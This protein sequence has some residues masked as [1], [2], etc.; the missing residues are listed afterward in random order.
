MRNMYKL[1]L[2]AAIFILAAIN[3]NAQSNSN[4][5]ILT[6]GGFEQWDR[7]GKPSG[8]RIQESLYPEQVK[9]SRPGGS[10]TEALKVYF[11]ELSFYLD[12]SVPV[13]TETKYT[14]SFWY[15]G[16]L[17]YKEIKLSALW[18][19]DGSI[20]KRDY[21]FILATTDKDEWKQAKGVI[22][23]PSDIDAMTMKVKVDYGYN[24]HV[25]FDDFS[26]IP[27][28]G[29]ISEPE[30]EAP[31]N[32]KIT[33][34]QGEMEISW[35]KVDDSEVQWEVTFDDN[36]ETTTTENVFVKTNLVPGSN[37]T[38]K[39]RAVKGDVKSEFSEKSELT[40]SMEKGI[41][42]PKRI[43]YLRT[44]T[45]DG[46][47]EGRTLK[48]YFNE[49]ANPEAKISYK[50]NGNPIEP[51]NN[52]LEFPAFNEDFKKFQLEVF[53]NEDEGRE[54]EITYPQLGVKNK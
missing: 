18:W 3:V 5:E 9:D 22:T 10:G 37:H 6:N 26:V 40:Q 41:N 30:L 36:V 45:P 25:I 4:G 53:I 29:G 19:K 48:L 8:W 28:G 49:L 17:D 2:P 33:P 20:K 42:D 47:S 14:F 7:P 31:Q 44:V 16:N 38:V 39:I 11:N 52:T 23:S 32:L 1:L 24:G 50:L 12:P 35:D 13:K 15:K 51:K 54:W 46:N 34:Y 27:E 43:P 21:D